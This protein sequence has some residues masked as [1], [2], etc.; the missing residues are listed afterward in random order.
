MV[1]RYPFLVSVPHGGLGVPEEVADRLYLSI[2][3]LVRLSDP[4]TIDLF[5][6]RGRIEAWTAVPVSRM[7]VD[8]NRSP[9]DLPPRRSDGVVKRMTIEGRPVYLPGQEPPIDLVHRL[10]MEHYFPFHEGIDHRIDEDGVRVAF[11]CHSM[12][13]CGPPNAPDAGQARPEIC[14]GNHGD[15]SGA[16]RPHRLATCPASWIVALAGAFRN[17]FP[18]AAVSINRPYAGGFTTIAH[19]W[20]RGVP[21]IQIEVN[22]SLY[23]SPEGTVD[24]NRLQDLRERTWRALVAFWE[25]VGDEEPGHPRGE[26]RQHGAR[27]R[28]CRS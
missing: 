9:F 16:P 10:M 3:D 6:Y 5:D 12:M 19:Y 2:P 25:V 26:R 17:E 8:V 27:M 7:V 24:L 4:A 28:S 20:H 15:T 23:E 11:D 1:E 21:Y 18:S 14:L 22:R 13:D